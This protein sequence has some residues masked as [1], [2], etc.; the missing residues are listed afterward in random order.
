MLGD[1]RVLDAI[2][3]RR[4][5]SVEKP[6]FPPRDDLDEDTPAD[7]STLVGSGEP[8][9]DVMVD[10]LAAFA[11]PPPHAAR[12]LAKDAPLEL[13]ITVSLLRRSSNTPTPE[14]PFATLPSG[15]PAG[16][17]ALNGT[18]RCRPVSRELITRF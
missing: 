17:T 8:A 11:A 7:A 13:L 6:A 4:N 14:P 18:R 15:H 9:I 12:G 3:L 10:A 5:V 2:R 16:G 1:A